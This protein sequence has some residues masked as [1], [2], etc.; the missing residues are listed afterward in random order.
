MREGAPRRTLGASVRILVGLCLLFLTFGLAALWQGRTLDEMRRQR[1]AATQGDE[2]GADARLPGWGQLVVGAPSGA[3]PVE[4]PASMQERTHSNAPTGPPSPTPGS[5]DPGGV[6]E[7]QPPRF[8]PPFELR[9]RSGQRLWSL[10]ERHYDRVG[11]NLIADIAAYNGI[12]DPNV[13]EV[14][15]LLH[16][17]SLEELEEWRAGG[18]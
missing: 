6:R 2:F 4:R 15:Q 8:P 18:R 1:D 12:P 16:L 11:P 5:E 17:P 13:I 7:F 10:L 9:I 3:E 14:G